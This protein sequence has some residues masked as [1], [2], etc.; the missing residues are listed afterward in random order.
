MLCEWKISHISACV[1]FIS[2]ALF[3][4]ALL[5][6]LLYRWKHFFGVSELNSVK[7]MY[8]QGD[9]KPNLLCEV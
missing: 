3:E 9:A 6:C 2:A 5:L 4:F 8:G 1:I 7:P